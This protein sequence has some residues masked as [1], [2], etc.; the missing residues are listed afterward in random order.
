[1]DQMKRSR[2]IIMLILLA[3]LTAYTYTLRYRHIPDPIPPA[4]GLIPTALD[5]YTG[6]DEYQEPESLRLLGADT[7][8]FRSYRREDG[9]TVWLF[10]G[11]FGSPQ[12]NSQIHS[13][14]H[15]YPGVGWNIVEEG[16]TNIGTGEET[17]HVRHLIITDGRETRFVLYWF[18]THSGTITNE[19]ELKWHQ[20]KSALLAK[21]PSASFIRFSAVISDGADVASRAW[22]IGFVERMYPIIENTLMNRRAGTSGGPEK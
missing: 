5:D 14:K 22:L 8:L 18:N 10:I 3:A 9:R 2:I 6:R 21:S 7:T 11:H 13:P 1:M 16:R 4:L 12:E 17:A 19:F 15:C 20:M